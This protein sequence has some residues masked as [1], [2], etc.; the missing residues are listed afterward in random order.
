M[1]E[2]KVEIKETL[3]KEIRWGKDCVAIF[4]NG[5]L[6]EFILT[7]AIEPYKRGFAE[8]HEFVH[9]VHDT[10]I[11]NKPVEPKKPRKERKDKGIS[12]KIK[13]VHPGI[14][15]IT[16]VYSGQTTVPES[17]PKRLEIHVGVGDE[18]H[19]AKYGEFTS[20]GKTLKG[21]LEDL[22]NMLGG[23]WPEDMDERDLYQIN[24]IMEGEE[25]ND[26]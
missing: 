1:T 7:S 6:K 12:K 3:N 10:L 5:T 14:A 13:Q 15:T 20:H 8:F 19:S 18:L 21:A 17:I 11:A 24:A 23:D 4:E 25:K 26:G 9:A 22:L 2:S 16:E